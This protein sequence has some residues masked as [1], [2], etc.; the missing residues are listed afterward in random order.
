MREFQ[1]RLI[2]FVGEY[3]DHSSDDV[4][5]GHDHVTNNN[6]VTPTKSQYFGSFETEE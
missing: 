5:G 4:T 3:S 2:R 6:F 1:A